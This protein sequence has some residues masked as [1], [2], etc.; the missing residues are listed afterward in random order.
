MHD[1]VLVAAHAKINLYLRVLAR[2]ESGYHGIETI[3]QRIAL[4]DDVRVSLSNDRRLAC[5]GP[6]M[7]AA[8]LGPVESN[9]A[10]R[11]ALLY[12]DAARRDDGFSIDI[13]KNIPVGGGLG[14][15]STDAAATLRAFDTLSTTPLGDARLLELAAQLGSDVPFLLTG[16]SRALAW[17]RGTRMLE[18]P[19]LP[20]A[21]VTLVT[22][23]EGVD[24]GSA[25]RALAEQR[26]RDH[27]A[28]GAAAL[29][30]SMLESWSGVAE[31]ATND[32]ESVVSQTHAG[33]KLALHSLR[34][35][36]PAGAI[37]MMS[38]S[39]ATCYVIDT[40]VESLQ[41][42]P[43]FSGARLVHTSTL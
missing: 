4:H 21:A 38:G 16:W 1:S 30:A 2:E 14:G 32:F 13:T 17:G 22:F 31:L 25:Y 41:I 37:T 12:M 26:L 19:A 6:T 43:D 29:D 18:L 3:F 20:T 28:V 39:G 15:G 7:P 23:D 5:A 42:D 40:D 33:V 9:L 24:T 34:S 35:V 8:G 27:A 11:A 10:Y 36:A